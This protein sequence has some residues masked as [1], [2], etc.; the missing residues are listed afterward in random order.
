IPQDQLPLLLQSMLED[1]FQLKAHIETRELPVYNLVVAKD[2]PKLKLNEDQ[3]PPGP[4]TPGAERGAGPRGDAGAR[5]AAP[6]GGPPAPPAFDPN[7]PPPRGAIMIQ[8]GGPNGMK[9]MATAMP[10]AQF[11]NFLQQTVGRTVVDKTDL[12]GLFDIS[13]TFSPEG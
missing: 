13:F 11:V 4:P 8:G 12:K 5:G 9:L 7:R 3:T 2:G 1:R 10:L 6:G